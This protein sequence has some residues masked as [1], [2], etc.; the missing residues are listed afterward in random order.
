MNLFNYSFGAFHIP[1]VYVIAGFLYILVSIAAWLMLRNQGAFA[2]TIW[3]VGGGAIG[4]G[5]ALLGMR[6]LVTPWLTFLISN[7]ALVIGNLLHIYSLRKEIKRPL[8]VMT[9]AI[10]YVFS[11]IPFLYFLWVYQSPVL[12]FSWNTGCLAV[13]IGWTAWLGK[14]IAD[15]ESNKSATWLAG[16]YAFL[17]V[18]MGSRGLMGY[19]GIAGIDPLANNIG[20]LWLIVGVV[21]SAVLGNV[22]IIGLY[23]ERS[24]K[25]NVAFAKEQEQ[26]SFSAKLSENMAEQYRR[27]SLDEMSSALAHELGQPITGILFDSNMVKMRIGNPSPQDPILLESV[28]SLNKHALRARDILNSIRSFSK[29]AETRYE[30]MNLLDVVDDVVRLKSYAV[31]EGKI[32]LNV[33]RPSQRMLVIG[34]RVL[35]S[36]VFLNAF[37]NSIEARTVSGPVQVQVSFHLDGQK[38]RVLIE[39]DGPGFSATSLENA[40]KAYFT[41]KDEGMGVGLSLC[42]RILEQH[43]GEMELHNRSDKRGAVVELHLPLW[44]ETQALSQ[45]DTP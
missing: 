19:F 31:R 21:I 41:T 22:A 14:A 25:R 15:K 26:Q 2:P 33:Q 10:I 45:Q 42:R 18:L 12:R 37:R 39:D 36:L 44:N 13:L 29:P 20:N 5:I 35:L 8:S 32:H 24:N 7:S 9:M 3:C 6:G 30:V 23:L 11:M 16:V 40:G 34:N 27:R 43:N 1:T 17:M 38:L 4:V 28:E